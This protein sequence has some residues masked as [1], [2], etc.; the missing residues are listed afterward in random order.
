[1]MVFAGHVCG[2]WFV[3]EAYRLNS[4]ARDDSTDRLAR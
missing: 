2:I 3:S 4:A 1:M